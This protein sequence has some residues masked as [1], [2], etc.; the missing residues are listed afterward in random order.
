[1][2]ETM[3]YSVKCHSADNGVSFTGGKRHV[4]TSS[5]GV[6]LSSGE[7]RLSRG[8]VRLI[9]GGVRLR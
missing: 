4:N 5:D 2:F 3:V 1:M 7:M 9:S 6:R 8:G